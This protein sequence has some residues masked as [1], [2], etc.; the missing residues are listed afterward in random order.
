MTF[1]MMAGGRPGNRFGHIAEDLIEEVARVY[2]YNN[3]PNV[4]PVASLQMRAFK[5]AALSVPQMR[6]VLV[7]RGYQ[8]AITYSFVDPKVQQA[9]F[10]NQDALVLPNP[11]SADMSA[12]RLNL[13]PGLLQAVQYNQSRQQNR[14]RLFE[15]GLKFIPDASAEGGVRQIP[16]IGGVIIGSLANEHWSIAERP[17][18]FYDVKADVEALLALLSNNQAICFTAAS[19]VPCTLGKLLPSMLTISWRV[20]WA[21]CIQKPEVNRV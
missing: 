1:C 16:V 10:A 3:I 7:D 15:Y 11:I 8:E 5:E 17:V 19:I 2:G 13:W 12:M 21:R 4:A 18:D 6:Q 14:L 20:I 9:L